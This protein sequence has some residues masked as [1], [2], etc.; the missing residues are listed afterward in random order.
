MA[1]SRAKTPQPPL[2]IA[3]DTGGTFTDCVWVERGKLRMAKVFSTPADPSQAIAEALAQANT[4]GGRHS[5]ARHH[6][7]HQH[8]AAAQRRARGVRH[9]CGLRGHHRDRP[10]EPPQA[11]R[12]HLRARAAAGGTQYALRRARTRRARRRAF[13]RSP[14][15]KI[16]R[17]WRATFTPAA[18]N[19]SPSPRSSPSPIRKTSAPSAACS[20]NSGCRSRC[21][22]S[23]CRS[24]A[25]TNAPAPSSSTPTFSR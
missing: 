22:T 8:T 24:S 23:S 1:A 17:C 14:R 12:P 7:R 10:P 19:P 20:R 16:S 6:G 13:C 18:R 5:S 4:A 2:R 15:A 21:R 11:L 9:Y 25:S 3:V